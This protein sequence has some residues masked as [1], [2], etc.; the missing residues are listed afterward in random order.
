MRNGWEI[1]KLGDVCEFQNG[2]AFKSN[3]YK[4]EGLPIIRITNIQNDRID[5]TDLVYFNNRDYKENFDRYKV[6]KGDLLIAMSGATT[7]KLGIN[8]SDITYYLNQRV[9]KFIPNNNLNKS[10]LYYF[11]S[12]KVEESLRISIVAAQPN[13]STE[14]IKNFEIP[15]PS[16]SEQKRIVEILDE[17][18]AA[19][20][21][22][23]A[24]VEKNLQNAKE[25]F[26]SY[27]QNV[28]TNKGDDWEEKR[29]ADI[30]TKIGSGSTPLGGEKA[31]KPTGT[32]LIRSLNVH[33]SDFRKKDLA[34]ID[35]KQAS[36]LNGV[37]IEENDILFNI[38]GASVAR[39]CIVPKE[40]LPARVN[41]HVSIIRVK[42]QIVL[43]KFIQLSLISKENKNKL[44]KTG[45][46]GATRQAITK[47]Q[48]EEF[49]IAYPKTIKEQNLIINILDEVYVKT[50]LL[51]INYQK[52]LNNLEE[53]KKS[54]LQKAFTGELTAS[55]KTLIA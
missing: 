37:I 12:T 18:F 5:P 6:I 30:T 19:I 53:L 41:Q 40:I 33:D 35:D 4:K 8:D 26:E 39:C 31:Y 38:T 24:N 55:N 50:K 16:L 22:A 10:Y 47:A 49:V 54:I 28:F 43:P 21:K 42:P 15:F 17:A 14:Q 25:L 23:K 13:L 51:E 11:L 7:G 44:L 3:T 29:L 27:L 52:K 1:K 2:F 34:F 45:E 9:G 20:D 46:Q 36:K 48:L 32:S